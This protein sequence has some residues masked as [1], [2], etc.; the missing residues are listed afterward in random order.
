[1]VVTTT[2]SVMVAD[3]PFGITSGGLK[4]NGVMFGCSG[5][6]PPVTG[7]TVAVTD[8]SPTLAV[9]VADVNRSALV[10]VIIT[11]EVTIGA[12]LLLATVNIPALAVAPGL[13]LVDIA[14]D[15]LAIAV[16]VGL[17][18]M[19]VV[20]V[21]VMVAVG[22]AVTPGV[23]VLVGVA[24]RVAVAVAVGVAVRVAVAVAVAVG[25]AV[26]VAVDVAVA[27]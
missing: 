21:P 15:A 16:G 22:V 6:L 27:V 13:A 5:E 23:P 1:V 2:D 20:G 18:V 19:L 14:G 25:V 8:V 10:K 9:T 4:L 17:G 26:A 24:V 3:S 12:P 7:L 11:C